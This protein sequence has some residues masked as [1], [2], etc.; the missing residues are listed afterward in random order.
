MCSNPIEIKKNK[1]NIPLDKRL[2]NA[3]HLS[4]KCK[5]RL[6]AFCSTTVKPHKRKFHVNHV[7]LAYA[8]YKKGTKTCFQKFHEK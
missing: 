7:M 5:P 4:I 6:C 2:K 1:F 3:E 8:W